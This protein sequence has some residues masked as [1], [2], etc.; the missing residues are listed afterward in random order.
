MG[1]MGR[2][3]IE[4]ETVKKKS[5]AAEDLLSHPQQLMLGL[6]ARIQYTFILRG[7]GGVGG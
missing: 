4:W 6:F 1:E 3:H 7:G 2:L 5:G